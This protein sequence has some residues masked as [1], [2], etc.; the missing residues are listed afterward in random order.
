MP[1]WIITGL[2][3]VCIATYVPPCQLLFLTYIFLHFA[4]GSFFEEEGN[5]NRMDRTK[6]IIVIKTKKREQAR[7]HKGLR[8]E[9]HGDGL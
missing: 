7:R 3:M 8:E 4:F 1:T 6:K 9:L 2:C 5:E